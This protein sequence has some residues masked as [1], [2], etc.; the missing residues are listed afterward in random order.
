MHYV[1]FFFFAVVVT[2]C[3]LFV[4]LAWCWISF[5]LVS[6]ERSHRIEK[7]LPTGRKPCQVCM[8][9]RHFAPAKKEH[10]TMYLMLQGE[11]E[12]SENQYSYWESDPGLNC[13]F[14]SSG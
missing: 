3:S 7:I 6:V 4:V 14:C 2:K 9:I 1:L 5:V 8:L 13:Q 11:Q 10:T 12:E